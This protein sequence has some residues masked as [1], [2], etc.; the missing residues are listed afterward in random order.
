MEDRHVIVPSI[1]EK[2]SLSN[3]HGKNYSFFGV[4]DGHGGVDAAHFIKDNLLT[5]IFSQSSFF[6]GL[7]RSRI[8]L[9]G[10]RGRG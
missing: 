8:I 7:L 2:F 6:S 9:E 1:N 5:N 3:E 4:F 10:E